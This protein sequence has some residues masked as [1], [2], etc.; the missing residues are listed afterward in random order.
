MKGIKLFI[1]FLIAL[2]IGLTSCSGLNLGDK[3]QDAGDEIGD[4]KDQIGDHLGDN[5]AI[6][7]ETLITS[8]D[9][10]LTKEGFKK[11]YTNLKDYDFS[12]VKDWNQEIGSVVDLLD[13]LHAVRNDEIVVS[14]FV[15]HYKAI[16][17]TV[18]VN[19]V[20]IK[21]SSEIIP[22]LP[23]IRNYYDDSVVIKDWGKELDACVASL[24]VL[25][26]NN[27]RTLDDLI[28]EDSKLD[29]SMMIV[30]ADSELI[31]AVM[32]KEINKRISNVEIINTEITK[33]D[34]EQIDTA[35]KWDLELD[36]IFDLI[37]VANDAST[38]E[39]SEIVDIYNEIKETIL[40]K[41][42]LLDAA[43]E[44]AEK[45]PVVSNYYNESLEIENWENELDAIVAS[46]DELDKANIENLSDLLNE[47]SGLNGTMMKTF[48]QSAILK[49]A[50]VE[51][52]NKALAE[53]N[54][55]SG[56]ITVADV[57]VLSEE[58]W[59]AELSAMRNL[60]SLKDNAS[61]L[62][63]AKIVEIYKEVRSTSLCNKVLIASAPTM[64][65][66]LPVV[67]T[68]YDEHVVINDWAAELD[69]IVNT[70][71]ALSEANSTVITNPLAVDS[72]L[73]GKV[74]N[75]ATKSI[76]LTK[77]MV[78]EMNNAVKAS[79]LAENIITVEN[80]QSVNTVEAWD[81]ELDCMRR[82]VAIDFAN[83]NMNSVIDIYDD[84]K[85]NTILCDTILVSSAEII[86][87]DLPIICNYYDESLGITDWDQELDSIVS[88]YKLLVN[89]G[90]ANI[91]NPIET[92]DGEVIIACLE[93]KIL[94]AAFVEEFNN[95]LTTLGLGAYYTMDDAKLA[96]L[97][98]PAKWDN[99][100][101][102]IQAVSD[103]VNNFSLGKVP[104]VKDL[105]ENTIIAKAIL[106]AF[107][108]TM[109]I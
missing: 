76:I 43:P 93:S 66:T 62:E 81:A 49:N 42:I 87:P 96:E 101:A 99:E 61:T 6:L 36:A 89:K 24:E 91:T 104:A 21:C 69:S 38:M 27:I 80:I 84:V 1:V 16:R 95:N 79:G 97:D 103:L 64:A 29:G 60:I 48:V 39:Y 47:D 7:K 86:I 72:P 54:L 25:Y 28:S 82:L 12:K 92:L 55:E 9:E 56:L 46:V 40:C 65:E 5:T 32:V 45:L 57:E 3:I 73:N 33:A 41:K 18:F 107:L 8:V 22:V 13:L 74:L 11:C 34:F 100:L 77:A 14:D 102:A 98:T 83:T 10:V 52:L 105:V 31:K 63:F 30:F 2:T 50:L 19:D 58:A 78:D 90:L 94:K 26:E 53:S 17:K 23:I 67:S 59:D 20:L 88:A 109:G 51:E 68:Y 85:Q 37:D 108:L 4:I 106:V 15:E 44:L 75:A 35:E 71:D 70:L